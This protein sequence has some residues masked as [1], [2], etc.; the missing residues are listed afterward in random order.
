MKFR[1]VFGIDVGIVFYNVFMENQVSWRVH[2]IG[3]PDK[4][5]FFLRRFREGFL[6]NQ[7]YE[8]GRV[9]NDDGDGNDAIT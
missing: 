8:L 3:F 2:Y 6:E 5:V 1:V 9:G 7:S 4:S